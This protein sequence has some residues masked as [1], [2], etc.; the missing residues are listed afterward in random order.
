[1]EKEFIRN[2]VY[3]I[4]TSKKV[5][6]RSL[7]L[8]LGMSSEYINQLESG[9]LM[10]SLDFLINFCDYFNLTLSNFF[11]NDIKYPT[12]TNQLITEINKLS[13]EEFSL[14]FDLIKTINKN[15]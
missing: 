4:R 6:A 11:D 5:S 14:I 12:E 13:K 8:E 7:S 1:M 9:R 15:K 2:R 3:E 10:P